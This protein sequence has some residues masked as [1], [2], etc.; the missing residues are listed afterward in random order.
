MARGVT[1]VTEVRTRGLLV[2]IGRRTLANVVERAAQLMSGAMDVGLYGAQR[3]VQRR[4]NFL[5]RP[6]LDVAQH[7]AGAVFGPKTGNGPLDGRAQF[8][9]LEL[10]EGRLL[11]NGHVE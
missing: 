8:A 3:E 10:V 6:A 7:D 2:V 1:L 5:V 4:R 11:L 9:R